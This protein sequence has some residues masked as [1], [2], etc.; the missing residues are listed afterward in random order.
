MQPRLH[1]LLLPREGAAVP[2][3]VDAFSCGVGRKPLFFLQSEGS[4]RAAVVPSVH[5]A[6]PAELMDAFYAPLHA[7]AT[8]VRTGRPAEVDAESAIAASI[9]ARLAQVT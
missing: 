1:L 2:A 8:E 3:G 9:T 6:S 7:G 4:T 5:F